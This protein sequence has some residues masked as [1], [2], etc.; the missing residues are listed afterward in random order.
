[1]KAF[2]L[3]IFAFFAVLLFEGS[4]CQSPYK[5]TSGRKFADTTTAS[6]QAFTI[7]APLAKATLP[8]VLSETLRDAI[9]R[10]TRLQLVQNDGD[11]DFEGA[12]TGYA[13][14]PVAVGC[15]AGGRRK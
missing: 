8:Q 13:I 7:E 5:F 2:R 6:V 14:T 12:I 11:L 15:G 9:Q 10:Q 1:M 3:I 4:H